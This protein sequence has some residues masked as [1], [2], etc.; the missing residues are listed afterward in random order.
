MSDFQSAINVLN[1]D[2][3]WFLPMLAFAYGICMGS[4]LNVC[5]YRIPVGRSV[6]TPRSACACGKP[7]PWFDNL[8]ILSWLLLRG[9]ARCCGRPFSFRYP[10]VEALTGGLF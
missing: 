8:P 6:V 2:K 1:Q 4:F 10:F 7:L 5:I 3:P 9:K